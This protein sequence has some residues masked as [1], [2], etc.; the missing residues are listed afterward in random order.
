MTVEEAFF[1][2]CDTVNTSESESVMNQSLSKQRANCRQTVNRVLTCQ[3]AALRGFA[4]SAK[5]ECADLPTEAE[6]GNCE[7]DVRQQLHVD[8]NY[9]AERIAARDACDEVIADAA[10]GGCPVCPNGIKELREV[11]DDG[12][13]NN[14]DTCT[15]ACQ[16]HAI[17]GDAILDPGEQCDRGSDNGK[18]NINCTVNCVRLPCMCPTPTPTTSPTPAP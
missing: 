4:K 10:A 3:N 17:C 18:E 13:F 7:Q 6:R 12:N 14:A 8:L 15:T 9:Q 11:C 2:A 16:R 5:A 1:V